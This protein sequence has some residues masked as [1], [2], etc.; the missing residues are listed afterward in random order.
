MPKLLL[1]NPSNA[2]KG[3]GN[4]TGTAWPPLNLPYI[5]ALTPPGYEIEAIDENI[6][7]FEFRPADL[8]GITAYT[9]SAPRAYEISAI[10]RSRGIPVVMGGIHASMVPEEA[11]EHCDS[12]VVGEAESVWPEVLA[13]FEAGRLRKR[14][15]GER[16]SLDDLPIPRRDILENGYY[17]WGSIQTSRGCPMNCSFCSVTAFNGRTFRRRPLDSVMAELEKIPQRRVLLADDNLIGFGPEDREWTRSFFEAVIRRGIRKTFFAQASLEFG[18]DPELIRL[19]ASAGLRIVFIGMESVQPESLA[20]F[21]KS[22]NLKELARARYHELIA[23][24]RKGG[25]AVLGAFVLGCDTDE[26]S[27]FPRTLDFILSSGI[28]VIQVTKPTPLPGTELWKSLDREGRILSKNFPE[29]WT[30]YRFT[31]MLYEPERMTVDE[32]YEGFT[33]LRGKFYSTARTLA[34]TLSTLW[35]TKSPVAALLSYKFN[36]SYRKA[37]LE[38]EH[39]RRFWSPALRERFRRLRSG[40]LSGGP[41]PDLDG[42]VPEVPQSEA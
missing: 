26:P 19:A 16:L 25:I 39:Y 11:Q 36:A 20:A 30:E 42:P 2:H 22:V 34:R 9:A 10:F 35:T 4:V 14:Y 7:P 1:I 3:L 12:V 40:P 24:I 32:V 41:I 38:S 8:V 21:H 29:D 27:V 28:D 18:E 31:K 5:A 13:D 23:R 15:D 33:W 6:R 37:F 17:S